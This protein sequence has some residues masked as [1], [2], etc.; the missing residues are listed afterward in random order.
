[1]IN[2]TTAFNETN[3][4]IW[5]VNDISGVQKLFADGQKIVSDLLISWDMDPASVYFRMLV[6]LMGVIIIYQVFITG[7][8]KT[9]GAFRYILMLVIV[10]AVLV[11][12]GIL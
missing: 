7:T 4:T 9:G 8:S 11:A 10:F 2:N 1:M 5:Q 6:I 12:L 3:S